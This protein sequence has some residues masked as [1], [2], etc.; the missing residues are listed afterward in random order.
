VRWAVGDVVAAGAEL[1]TAI[2]ERTARDGAVQTCTAEDG[3]SA[4]LR[5]DEGATVA[6]DTTSVARVDLPARLVVL[7]TEGTA[8]VTADERIV[9]HTED[10]VR[11][12]FRF[13]PAGQDP[14][15]VPMQRWAEVVRDAVVTGVVPE[16][17][18]TFADGVACARVMDALRVGSVSR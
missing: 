17:E 4:W 6:I 14:H 11:E 15:L 1:R 16:G 9:L 13:D 12:V 3:F 5:T 7:G 18:P 2:P 8:E 10:G